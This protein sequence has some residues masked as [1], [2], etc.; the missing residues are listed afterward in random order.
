ME[1]VCYNDINLQS[2]AMIFP[3]HLKQLLLR[4]IAQL[5]LPEAKS[6]LRHHRHLS[7][8]I[9]IGLLDL[10]RG[11]S[12][13]DPVVHLLR[14]FGNP[15]GHIFA[16]G[17]AADRRIVPQKSITVAGKCKRDTCLRIA[18]CQLQCT[19]LDIQIR[20]LI[21]AHSVELLTLD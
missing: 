12:R 3:C 20:L 17:H 15:L 7:G 14:G 11:I 10:C 1:K 8:R 16:K 5:A 4:L 2:T 21:L 19:A 6:V 18:M 13:C 9:C